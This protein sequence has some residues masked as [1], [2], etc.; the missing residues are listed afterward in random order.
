[1]PVGR[2]PE[3]GRYARRGI[4]FH[5][6]DVTEAVTIATQNIIFNVC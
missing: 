5:V 2:R 3:S 1:M 6:A 4:R